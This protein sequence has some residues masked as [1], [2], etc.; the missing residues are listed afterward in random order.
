MPDIKS[1]RSGEAEEPYAYSRL[2]EEDALRDVLS[3]GLQVTESDRPS[4]FSRGKDTALTEYRHD[5]TGHLASV[6]V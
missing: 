1:E 5:I 2:E 3:S 6:Y 4:M